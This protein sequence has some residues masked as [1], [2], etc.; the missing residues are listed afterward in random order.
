MSKESISPSE[1]GAYKSY[2]HNGKL[3]NN[4][5][6]IINGKTPDQAGQGDGWED[7]FHE[8]FEETPL[9]IAI[10]TYLGYILM[11]I[12]GHIHDLF[13]RCGLEK[14]KC[15]TEPKMEGYCPLLVPWESFFTRNIFRYAIDCLNR[16]ICS[17]PAATFDVM[18]RESH[19]YNW[20]FQLTGRKKRVM[21]FGSYNYL[22][23]A[24]NQQLCAETVR[25]I[26][27]K[28]GMGVCASRQE[29]GY[30][31]IH[32]QLDQIVAE[33]L[34][35]EAAITVPMGF[36]TNSMNMP[37]LVSKGCLILSDELNHASLI[38]GSRLTG[39]AIHTYKHNNMKDLEE[40]L[41]QAVCEGQPRTHRPWKKILIVVEGVYSMEGSIVQLPEVLRLKRKYKAYIYLDEAHSVGA[42]GSRGRGVVDYFGLDPRDI[43]IMMGT[44]TKSFGSCGGYIAGTKK[45]IN[46]LRVQ[47]HSAIYS[48]TMSAPITQQV[49]STM[50][51][52]MGH[53][54]AQEGRRR[55][56][57]LR[58]NTRYF[59]QRLEEKGFI[60]YG[61]KDSPVVP[62][63]IYLPAKIAL[64]SRELFSRECLKRGLGTVVVG[65]PA[66]S[67]IEARAR[68]CLS[69]AHSKEMLDKAIEV[70]DE[71][72]TLLKMKYS[73]RK[74]LSSLTDSCIPPQ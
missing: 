50:N 33:F 39:A 41:R 23:F 70:V 51:I 71:V 43:D 10:L 5:G 66:T 31:D 25:D 65:F 14:N 52:I 40:K 67:I 18:E 20:T 44:F 36:A 63:L 38:L 73:R 8:S 68:F 69:A 74:T 46:H 28:Y 17:A 3:H 30:L 37:A 21:N 60:L 19:D 2:R 11:I 26:T 55:I 13:R 22:G 12:I 57:Q 16:P 72:G 42:I 62:V 64:F 53:T 1:N 56:E 24:E 6:K 59:R 29:F 35:T 7:D 27:Q 49:I 32:R 48:S 15:S 45:L 47:S 54:N 58:W 4:N 9:K 34:G 61:N